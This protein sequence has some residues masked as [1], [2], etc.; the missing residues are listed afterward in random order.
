MTS[1]EESGFELTLDETYDTVRNGARLVLTYDAESNSF[2]GFVENTTD[3]P[4]KQVRIEVHLSNGVEL[5]PTT[6]TDLSPG[7]RIEVILKATNRDF[8]D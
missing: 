3:K 1:E 6:P 5:G 8:D 7:E 4:L 2:I